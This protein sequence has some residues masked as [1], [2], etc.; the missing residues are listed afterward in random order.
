M[1]DTDTPEGDVGTQTPTG[2][3]GQTPEGTQTLK[4]RARENRG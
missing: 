4:G 2:E 1:G 3:E